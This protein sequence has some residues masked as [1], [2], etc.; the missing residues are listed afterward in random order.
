MI[1]YDIKLIVFAQKIK[2]DIFE[3]FLKKPEKARA[4]SGFSGFFKFH[5][6]KPGNKARAFL[7]RAF[8][9]SQP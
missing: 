5:L 2:S 7:S 9:T 8:Y 1:L 6:K 4:F 3:N